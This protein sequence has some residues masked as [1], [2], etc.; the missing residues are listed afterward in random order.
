LKRLPFIPQLDS[1]RFF[2]VLIVIFYHWLPGYSVLFHAEVGVGFFFVLSGYLISGNLLYL[3]QSVDSE[4]MT[5]GHALLLFYYRR[6]LRIFP[7]YYLV[8]IL[9]LLAVPAVF[10]GNFTWYSLYAPNLLFF[11]IQHFAGMLCHFWSLGIE[12]QFY[13]LWPMLIIF[14]PWRRLKSLFICTV[15]ASILFK[16]FCSFY[17]HNGFYVLLP[18]SQFD[19][20]GMGA[21]L[22]YLPFSR[23]SSVLEKTN[24]RIILFALGLLLTVSARYIAGLGIL[25]NLGLAGCGL[26]IIA[27]A[28]RGFRG[29]AGKILDLPP[30]QYLGKISYGLYVYHN[31]MPWLWRCLSGQETRYPLPIALFTK[32]WMSNAWVNLFAQLGLLLIIASLSW[33]L[34]EK[35]INK[36][37]NVGIIRKPA[38]LITPRIS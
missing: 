2:S 10:D 23:F 11:R 8:I 29:L 30:L 27:Q 34:F 31:L 24:I 25:Y 19:Y 36:L 6:A 17:N 9:L 38:P 18:F 16:V 4:E 32:H 26:M 14:V 13:F 7:L 35:P 37:K 33:F 15:L 21:L 5:S 20:F 3:K 1:F 12:E 28:Q 22:A